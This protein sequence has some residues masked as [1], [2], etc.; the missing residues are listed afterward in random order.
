MSIKFVL[1]TE[2]VNIIRFLLRHHNFECLIGVMVLT[3]NGQ[4]FGQF[5]ANGLH[6]SIA[7]TRIFLRLPF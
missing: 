3:A 5:T 4:D 7:V 1:I 6:L 2:Y